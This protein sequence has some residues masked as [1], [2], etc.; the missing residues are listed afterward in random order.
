M[1]SPLRSYAQKAQI[2]PAAFTFN[3]DI[4]KAVLGGLLQNE[5]AIVNVVDNLNPKYF[6]LDFHKEIY[7]LS[8]PSIMTMF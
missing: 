4:E 2:T 3:P 8:M 5:T 7:E 6:F 1:N